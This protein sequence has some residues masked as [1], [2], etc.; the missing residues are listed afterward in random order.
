MAVIQKNVRIILTEDEWEALRLWAAKDDVS[1]T[2]LVSQLLTKTI[3]GVPVGRP[4]LE[5]RP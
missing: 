4:R 3:T 5:T 2:A 1:V